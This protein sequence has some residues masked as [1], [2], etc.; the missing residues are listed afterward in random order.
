VSAV[1]VPAASLEPASYTWTALGTTAVLCAQEPGAARIR[2]AVQR[3]IDAID[4]AASRFADDSELSHLG[5]AG[6]ERRQVSPLLMEALQ[7]ALRAAIVTEG[8]VDPTLGKSL[9]AIGYDRD[10]GQLPPV[11]AGRADERVRPRVL[12]RR[13]RQLWREIRLWDDPPTVQLPAGVHLDLGATAKALACDRAARAG[14]RAGAGGGVLVALGGDIATYGPAPEGGWTVRVTDDH[15]DDRGDRG[16]TISMCDGGLATSSVVA[17]QWL[18]HGSA[19]HHILDPRTGTPVQPAWRTVS[20][21]AASCADANIA[22]TASI[23]LGREALGWLRGQ[24]LPARLVA[25]DGT[26]CVQ[27]GWPQ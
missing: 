24:G 2:A 3:E 1:D 7:L 11:P 20:V 18:H 14:H 23:V 9:V 15:R 21:A 26:V 5:R 17:R 16:Q 6:G 8:A 13:R 25:V 10:F 12:V 19:K 27:G 22:S 4:A